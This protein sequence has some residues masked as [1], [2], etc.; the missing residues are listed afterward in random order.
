MACA[1]Y[2]RTSCWACGGRTLSRSCCRSRPQG[3]PTQRSNPG[4]SNVR[5]TKAKPSLLAGAGWRAA[6]VRRLPRLGRR[7]REARGAYR[8]GRD[9]GDDRSRD[10]RCP[11]CQ[12]TRRPESAPRAAPRACGARLSQ[13]DDPGGVCPRAPHRQGAGWSDHARVGSRVGT[14]PSA[15]FGILRGASPARCHHC[16]R[17]PEVE[18]AL[19]HAVERTRW[20]HERWDR[21]PPPELPEQSVPSGSGRGVRAARIQSR[22]RP[23]GEAKGEAPGSALA[24]RTRS[25]A[26]ARGRLELTAPPAAIWPC[27]S[28]T[29][30]SPPSSSRV[31]ERAKCWASRSATYPLIGKRSPF[32]PTSGGGSR[33]PRPSVLCPCGHSLKRSCGP[34]YSTQIAHRAGWSS[35]HTAQVRRR[36]SRTSASCWTWLRSGPAGS[37]ERSGRGCSGTPTA[38]PGCKPS[39]KARRSACSR[40]RKSLGHGGEA[41]VRR[42][43]GHLGQVRH[44]AEEVEYRIEAFEDKLKGRLAALRSAV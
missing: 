30:C 6:R 29:R 23:D 2:S 28:R 17:R 40:S 26:A 14:L 19:A 27:R 31:A 18:R 34:T 9:A 4:G 35:L 32:G 13:G 15:G 39:T 3:R 8:S 44:R 10:R 20:H 38:P 12:A 37:R 25:R 43:Y 33:P 42:V 36:C 41:M 1:P 5:E 16:G 21:P 24:G 11:R 22:G 7:G